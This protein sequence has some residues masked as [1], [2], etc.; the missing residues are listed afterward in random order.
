MA[1][2]AVRAAAVRVCRAATKVRLKPRVDLQQLAVCK[3]SRIR[4]NLTNTCEPSTVD[5]WHVDVTNATGNWGNADADARCA[6]GM[7][8]TCRTCNWLT[9]VSG[10]YRAH[11]MTKVF[12][13][14]PGQAQ[15]EQCERCTKMHGGTAAAPEAPRPTD[16]M[17]NV[18][19]RNPRR[20]KEECACLPQL[21]RQASG[22]VK[23]LVVDSEE[24]DADVLTQFP[25]E[26]AVWPARVIFEGTHLQQKS[27]DLVWER[28]HRF[29]YRCIDEQDTRHAWRC[30]WSET[31]TW[32]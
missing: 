18:L 14:R 11:I 26:D 10:L 23:L 30:R 17:R 9:E 12:V 27:Y 21:V 3:A 15:A 24:L 32:Q 22:A 8:S 7:Y 31:S 6:E 13:Q 1:G 5:F 25:F 29:G 16:C 4:L 19:T 2:I 28:L 20:I